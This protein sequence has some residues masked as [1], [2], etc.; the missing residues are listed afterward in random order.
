MTEE[1]KLSASVMEA[2]RS[3]RTIEA[4]KRLREEKG[5]GLKEA[6]QIIDREI[7]AYR[8][9]NPNIS[10]QQKSSQWPVVLVVALIAGAPYFYLTKGS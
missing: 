3:E 9:T 2:V 8:S 1:V 6:K 5:I 10:L 4:I 7:A